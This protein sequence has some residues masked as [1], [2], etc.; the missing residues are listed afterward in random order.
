MRHLP[1]GEIRTLDIALESEEVAVRDMVRTIDEVDGKQIRVLGS[2]FKYTEN[3]LAEFS[4]P[5]HHAEHTHAVLKNQLKMDDLTIN[6]L[7][8]QG[9]IK[10]ATKDL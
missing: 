9:V 4:S 7:H 10:I 1:V 5:P 3:K 8:Q 6:A 2:P